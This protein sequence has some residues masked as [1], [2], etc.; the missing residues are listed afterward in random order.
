[1]D[2]ESI[3]VLQEIGQVLHAGRM[4]DLILSTWHVGIVS[5]H[6]EAEALRLPGDRLSN[7]T[8]A[9]QAQGSFLQPQDGGK[10]GHIPSCS[11]E[12]CGGR[13]ST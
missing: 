13:G 11:W 1:M 3:A 8:K 2:A 10:A 12:S 6:V 7:T 9:E 4:C 5:A